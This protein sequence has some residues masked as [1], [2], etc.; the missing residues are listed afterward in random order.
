MPT[1][2]KLIGAAFLTITA[3]YATYLSLSV[4]QTIYLN[5]KIYFVNAAIGLWVGWRSIGADPGMGGMGSIVSGMRGLVL[6]VVYSTVAFGCW[7]VIVKL[8]NFFIRNFEDILVSWWKGIL[9][10]LSIIS[11][12]EIVLVFVIGACIS[13]VSAGLA[14][15]YWS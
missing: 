1:A 11:A 10:Y 13:G 2:A 9:D 5:Y 14:N 4:E 15:R 7:V 3:L 12:P 6:L 8:Q